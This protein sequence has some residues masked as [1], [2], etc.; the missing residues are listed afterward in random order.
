M[1]IKEVLKQVRIGDL[2]FVYFLRGSDSF[3]Q[4]FFIEK[5]SKYYFIDSINDKTFLFPDEM[6]GK[7]IISQLFNEDLFSSKKLYILR[8]PQQIKGKYKD[9]LIKYCL[10]PLKSRILILIIDDWFDK[11]IITKKIGS[12]VD[13][14]DVRTPF[15]NEMRLWAKYFFKEAKVLVTGDVINML[16]DTGGDSLFHLKNEIEKICLWNMKKDEITVEDVQLFSG[17]KRERHRWEFLI[18]IGS[19]NFQSA[20]LLGKNIITKNESFLSLIYPLTALFQEILF[21]SLNS[22]TFLP[23]RSYKPISDSLMKRIPDFSKKF[24]IPEIY[25]VL[26]YLGYID[27][28]IK[29][30]YVNDENELMQFIELAIG[31]QTK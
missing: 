27:R 28:N 22:G 16:I 9:D 25:G 2:K 30:T 13:V 10:S 20:I 8:N 24:S 12:K 14:V 29:K 6:D 5:L 31:K 15:E 11:S 19:R 3:L 26:R 21:Y 23:N 17:W 18:A 7:E 1:K 4:S